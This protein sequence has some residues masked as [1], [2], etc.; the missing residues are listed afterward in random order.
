MYRNA[1]AFISASVDEGF[2]IPMSE[3]I[4]HE[5]SV[6]ASDIPVHHEN[7]ANQNNIVWFN[8]LEVESMTEAINTLDGTKK[9]TSISIN[10]MDFSEKFSLAIDRISEKIS[11][12]M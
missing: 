11:Q 7:F 9:S 8:P 3:A 2:D 1:F 5:L 10:E 12:E 6:L 4:F